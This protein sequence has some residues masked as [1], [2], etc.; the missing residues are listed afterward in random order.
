MAASTNLPAD[1]IRYLAA[2]DGY[3]IREGPYEFDGGEKAVAY[4]HDGGPF[5]DVFR[6]EVTLHSRGADRE[7]QAH[8]RQG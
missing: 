5:S 8:A 1:V 4:V 3:E 2:E 7:A 6:V